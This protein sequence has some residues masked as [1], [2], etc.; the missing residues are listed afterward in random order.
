VGV[1]LNLAVW[2]AGEVLFRVDG[3]DVFA[4]TVAVLSFVA[5]ERFRL[6]VIPLVGICAGV[7]LVRHLL[8]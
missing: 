8:G 6:G 2:F 1:V 7:G 3:I 5:L 4:V